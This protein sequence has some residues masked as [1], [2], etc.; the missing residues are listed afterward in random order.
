M[1]KYSFFRSLLN[2]GNK[3]GY[4]NLILIMTYEVIKFDFKNIYD[5][6]FKKPLKSG[7]ESYIPSFYYALHLLKKNI[8]LYDKIFIDFGCGRGRALK[9][10]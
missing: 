7:S 1:P 2:L 9:Y 8:V 6:K 10:L 5:Y 3:Y 4:L